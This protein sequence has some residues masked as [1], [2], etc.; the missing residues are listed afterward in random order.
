MGYMY[1]CPRRGN[2]WTRRTPQ[3]HSSGGVLEQLK[4]LGMHVSI[5]VGFGL[6][7]LIRL[8]THFPNGQGD[9]GWPEIDG[10]GITITLNIL[11][12]ALSFLLVYRISWAFSRWWEARGLVGNISSNLKMMTRSSA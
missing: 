1:N 5:G 9:E 6:V 7:S 11:G 8:A 2:C 3:R 4:Q 10:L 12:G